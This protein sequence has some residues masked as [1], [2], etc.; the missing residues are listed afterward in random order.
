MMSAKLTTLGLLRIKAFWYKGCDII[1]SLHDATKRIL[2]CDSNH[3][4]NVV[5][6]PMWLLVALVILSEKLSQTWFYKG[7]TRKFVFFGGSFCKMKI[8]DTM[9]F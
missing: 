9:N 6:W 1:I 3:I 5:M 7:L 2:S 4:A 8:A